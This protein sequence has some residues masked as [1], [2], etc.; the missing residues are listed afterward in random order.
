MTKP[1][2]LSCC[3]AALLCAAC[4]VSDVGEV[5]ARKV[6]LATTPTDGSAGDACQGNQLVG[7]S[8]GGGSAGSGIEAGEFYAV[9]L[10]SGYIA[11]EG[12]QPENF[13]S[14]LSLTPEGLGETSVALSTLESNLEIL[15][16]ARAF[17]YAG[18]GEGENA[19][20]A[21]GFNKGIEGAKVVL[22]S[23]DIFRGQFYS[24]DNLPIVGPA[25]YSGAGFGLEITVIELDIETDNQR[26]LISG[27]IDASSPAIFAGGGLGGAALTTILKSLLDGGNADDQ[28]FD[29]S[30]GFNTATDS[31]FDFVRFETGLYAMVADYTRSQSTDWA[32]LRL[33][34]TTGRLMECV[35]KDGA[36]A[37]R[38]FTSGSYFVVQVLKTPEEAEANIAFETYEQARTR[39]SEGGFTAAK[40]DEITEEIAGEIASAEIR[41]KI[42]SLVRSADGARGQ[43]E[44]RRAGYLAY[45]AADLAHKHRPGASNGVKA[46]S[47]EDA[48]FVMARLFDLAVKHAGATD[49]LPPATFSPATVPQGLRDTMN[50]ILSR[51]PAPTSAVN[52]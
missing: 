21:E 20:A 14:D 26:S 44:Y 41:R 48:D 45:Q 49:T 50:A 18:T 43:G 30:I 28:I 3:L 13:F 38:P 5:R 1:V 15:V 34:T 2:V 23:N 4:S 40:V 19:T 25:R 52:G 51:V 12:A 33:D 22:S 17:D 47:A 29:Y 31:D 35:A 37:M 32:N 24:D 39:M 16:V 46:M 27:I 10:R 36:T 8:Q 11:D 9:T 6:S 7:I 42:V